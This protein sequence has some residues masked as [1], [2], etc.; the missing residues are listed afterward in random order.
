MEQERYWA[1]VLAPTVNLVVP[2]GGVHRFLLDEITAGE[3]ESPDSHSRR[4]KIQ[5]VLRA[6]VDS[7]DLSYVPKLLS[8]VEKH[9]VSSVF[10]KLFR[11]VK[12]QVHSQR[13]VKLPRCWAMHVPSYDQLVVETVKNSMCLQSRNFTSHLH[14][15]GGS[16]MFYQFFESPR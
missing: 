10:D 7:F 16:H 5:W 14:R 1:R 9:V 2:F 6:G 4:D 3:L 13:G 15:R 12:E 11:E 8:V